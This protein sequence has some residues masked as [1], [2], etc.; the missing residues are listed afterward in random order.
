[1]EPRPMSARASQPRSAWDRPDIG[2]E[3]P[4]GSVSTPDQD[5][6]EEI[7]E[8]MGLTFEDDEPVDAPG[9]LSRRD[10]DRWEL[11]P[12][13]SEDYAERQRAARTPAESSDGDESG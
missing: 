9:K 11:R 10:Q 7:G 13:S 2:E 4:G 5:V 6:V 1:M 3:S 8:A 12:A